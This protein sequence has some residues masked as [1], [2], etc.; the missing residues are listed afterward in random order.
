MKLLLPILSDNFQYHLS[1]LV[2]IH[3]NQIAADLLK[4]NLL[5]NQ[6]NS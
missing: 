5:V 6:Y 2:E 3:E 1:K 4:V